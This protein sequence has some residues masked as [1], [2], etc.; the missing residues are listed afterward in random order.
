[1]ATPGI[2]QNVILQQGNGKAF[3]SWGL[4]A[5]ATNYVVQRSS[6]GVTFVTVATV[7]ANQY[8]D[9]AV[10]INTP[11]FY[12]VAAQNSSGNGLYAVSSP[13]SVI[14]TLSGVMSLGQARYLSQLTADRLNSNFVTTDEWNLYINQ[15]YKE[16]YDILVTLYEDLYV[17]RPA[18][19]VTTGSPTYNM[20]DG[21][22]SFIDSTGAS[23]V[24]PALYKITLASCGLA[25]NNN[26]W[27][28]LS[29]FNMID[30]DKYVYPQLTANYLGVFNLSYRLIGL[31]LQNQ[32]MELIPTPTAG[33]YIRI[34]YVPRVNDLVQDT[35]TLDSVSGWSE[36]VI[37]DAAIKVLRKEE[38]DVTLLL[39]QKQAMLERITSTASNRDAGQPDTISRTRN[40][41]GFGGGSFSGD[42]GFGG[43]WS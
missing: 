17:A 26:A 2:P 18:F 23:F 14:P 40:R 3:L 43:G 16:L 30:I 9:S 28:T 31:N 34:Y 37:L 36:Y 13:A 6:D 42:N 15:S 8:L 38:S 11:Y 29:K 10:S 21:V 27:V 20:P 33:Q 22:T 5:G 35:D 4:V 24:P 41:T 19:F 7:S 12:Q 39:N 32:L 25:M 1:M